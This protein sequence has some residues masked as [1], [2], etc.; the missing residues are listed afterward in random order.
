MQRNDPLML[1]ARQRI[2]KLSIDLEVQLAEK[3]GGAPAIE[4]V[5]RLRERAAESLMALVTVNLLDPAEIPKAVTLQNE[6]K[7]YDEWFGAIREII[8]EGIQEDAN[9]RDAEREEMLDYLSDRA[10][11][12]EV[13]RELGLIDSPERGMQD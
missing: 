9:L 13:A 3:R 1:L 5:N 11:G 2:I 10:D 6:V 4:I 7:R 12:E 8:Q